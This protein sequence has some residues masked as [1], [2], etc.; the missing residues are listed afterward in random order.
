MGKIEINKGGQRIFLFALIILMIGLIPFLSSIITGGVS[1]GG[2]RPDV[3]LCY[4]EG[5]SSSCDG[6]YPSNCPASGGTDYLSC[7][8]GSEESHSS[9]RGNYA[10]VNASYND[11]SVTNCV[12]ISM[13]QV[14]YEWRASSTGMS[15]C[16]I[17]IDSQGDG[18]YTI[19]SVCP[20]TSGSS[21]CID[22]TNFDSGFGCDD[23]F[24]L[25][26]NR[27]KIRSRQTTPNA[28]SITAYWDQLWY[29]VTYVAAG[30]L[31][32]TL[33]F[34]STSLTNNYLVYDVFII[35]ATIVCN[36]NVG[37][38]CG[39]VN[40][41]LRYN[42]SS[43]E[44][45]VQI[46]TTSGAQPFFANL[47]VQN[48]GKLNATLGQNICTL[49]WN[50]NATQSG[51]WKV[52]VLFQSDS[53]VVSSNNTL[54]AEIAVKPAI[55]S[56]NLSAPIVDSGI[57][58]QENFES[59]CSINCT[60]QDCTDV[61]VFLIY[62]NESLSCN[63]DKLLNTESFGLIANVNSVNLETVTGNTIELA[64]FIVTGDFYGDYV[65]SCNAS[66]SNAG[67]AL[68]ET[69]LPLHINGVPVADFLF[70][71]AN[72]WLHGTEILD[73]SDSIDYDGTITNYLFELDNNYG[74]SSSSTLCNGVSDSCSFNTL[75]QSQCIE[76]STSCYLKL[77][78]TDD[79]SKTNSTIIQI[80][81]DNLA[82]IVTLD[83]PKNDTYIL[84]ESKLINVSVS[85]F[86]SGV[87][88]VLFEGYYDSSWNDLGEDC[89][90]SYEFNWDLSSL[91]DQ[92]I[93]VRARANDSEGNLGDYD[94]H[95]N[96]TYD[97]TFPIIIL[98]SLLENE[99]INYTPYLLNV[100][101]SS[102][103]LSGIANSSWYY[104]SGAQW[105]LIGSDLN[106][107]DG[108]T[109]SWDIGISDGAY[110]FSI[111]VSDKAG[112]ENF[113][114]VENVVIDIV[115]E[116]P[117]CEIVYPNGGVGVNSIVLINASAS[118]S[119]SSDIV[120]NVSFEYSPDNGGT[121]YFIGLNSTEDLDY[122]SFSWDSSLDIDSNNYLV[123]CNVSDSRGGEGNDVSDSVFSVDNSPPVVSLFFP[124]NESFFNSAT[125]LFNFSA[126]DVFTDILECSLIL[127][128]EVNQTNSSVL[129][130]TVTEFV[131]SGLEEG[132][133]LWKVNCSDAG[134]N[135]DF[136]EERIF[137]TD[138]QAPVVNF[139]FPLD[140]AWISNPNLQLNYTPNEGHL[141]SCELWGNFTG[142][143]ELNQ[144]NSE[145]ISGVINSFEVFLE[146]GGY[147]WNVLCND[148]GGN[149]A[150]N[151]TNYS[152]YLDS[153]NPLILYNPSTTSSS[154]ISDKWIFINV[155]ANDLN[156]EDLWF[157]WTNSSG[158][159][160]LSFNNIDGDFYWENKSELDSGEYSFIV[161]INDSAGNLN[162]TLLRSITIDL[163]PPF[164]SLIN[165]TIGG[166]YS[167]VFHR[168][169]LINLSVNWSDDWGL[170]LA[171]LST[172][173]SGVWENKTGYS[174]FQNLSGVLNQSIFNWSNVSIIP[175]ESVY[176]KVYANDSLG[177]LN[178]SSE[179]GFEIWGWSE[180]GKSYLFPAGIKEG[181]ETTMFC[182]VWDNST[183]EGIENYN[184]SFYNETGFIGSNLTDS[185]GVAQ[186][187][188]N[189]STSGSYLITCNLTDESSLHYNDSLINQGYATLGVGYGLFVYDYTN[190]ENKAYEGTSATTITEIDDL[191]TDL[192]SDNNIYQEYEAGQGLYGYTRFEFKI[193]DA[194]NSIT[195]LNITWRGY[196]DVSSGT[197]GYILYIYNESLGDWQQLSSYTTN[198]VEQLAT[199]NFNSDF[200]NLINSTG[201]LKFLA[202]TYS[203][204]PSSGPTRWARIDTDYIKVEVYTDILAPIVTLNF[205]LEF[206]NSS[207]N[208]I[209]FSCYVDDDNFIENVSLYGDWNSWH[210][211][212]TNS[213]GLNL[214]YY[215][216]SKEISEGEYDWNCYSCDRAG[217]C[218]WALSNYSFTVDVTP[219]LV[220]LFYPIN[221]YNFSSFLVPSF[222]FSVIDSNA[223][224]NCSLYGDWNFWHLNQTINAPVNNSIL[225]FSSKIVPGDDY[226]IWNIRCID[227][228]G[229]VGSNSL[230]FSFASF[231]FPDKLNF[232]YFNISQTMNDGTGEITLYWNLSNHSEKYRV[233][234][235]DDLSDDFVYLNDTSD[236]NYTDVSFNGERRRFYRVDSWNPT[237]QNI[238]ETYFGAHVYS[239]NHNGNTRNWLGFP[240]NFSYLISASDSFNE[241]TNTTAFSM[242]NETI[243]GRVTCNLF[244]CPESF[245]CTTTNCD[246]NLNSGRG[247]EANLNSSAPSEVNW[248]GV[249]IVYD[250]INIELVKNETSFGKNWI[251][252]YV[253]TSLVNA[254][255]VLGSIENS[256]AVTTW[257]SN[258]QI[259][260]GLIPSPFP[261]VPYLGTNFNLNLE[262]GYEV[263]V[264]ADTSWEQ[265]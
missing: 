193:N 237:G 62:C 245:A 194:V 172:N 188:F 239:L 32:S 251:S 177:N 153:V 99:I 116:N 144:T 101:S 107:V 229:N 72:D 137:S 161:Y 119:D 238:S 71:L 209:N 138:Y 135:Q 263:S 143:W 117:I 109:Y 67:G 13:V 165:Q 214:V 158:S 149:S 215:N 31:N 33:N 74:F 222:N 63:P 157:E 27:A 100:S 28:P 85:D 9:R 257:D 30:N 247:Y 59:N 34:P 146:D 3:V 211:N 212:Q 21:G 154:L 35:N 199:F 185:L 182:E 94:I 24:G 198:N 136:S 196:G 6:G 148:T 40:G 83:E 25:G 256:D 242:W 134:S 147:L 241:I 29:N 218:E 152:F 23:F 104:F 121:W 93:E 231:L 53:G 82:P 120:K 145:V 38:T 118:D 54:N 261:W 131:V 151:A 246:F 221:N 123:R 226:Y 5:V 105:N 192:T 216:F 264:T 132:D 61:E 47:G 68:S 126:V 142:T 190:A 252:I 180:I 181:Y 69:D 159:F 262:G 90:G 255:D 16:A 203:V 80:G 130:N 60:G 189:V 98:D 51:P 122:Y 176:W 202:R 207:F 103:L 208:Q 14:C 160:N 260:R 36:G 223:L 253:N 77:T 220:D 156:K 162:S 170:S 44:P 78:V 250:K 49:V 244:S 171:W 41:T 55:L 18:W 184:V 150:F 141:D 84:S 163:I 206:Y 42:S 133:Y 195:K 20:G 115:N 183:S 191:Y 111:N 39:I 106:F 2:L 89:V 200:D 128:G 4:I 88:C 81:I 234:S 217:N 236:L 15:S 232:S 17:D 173:E 46:S 57:S 70:P 26:T 112:N 8:D 10:G 175:G 168:G 265:E 87:D 58:E 201:Y 73:A 108:L 19:Y 205:P 52:D 225:N 178:V 228:A 179:K 139:D 97:T 102:D 22:V 164:W 186:M 187:S 48:C 79:Y 227:Y 169:D 174:S 86:G 129:N 240:T 140:N 224:V 249:G 91:T 76:E 210:L 254:Q 96:I 127:N 243:Q 124:N 155:T 125:Q 95:G 11:S 258:S 45:N 92:V 75:I 37:D 114:L 56:A 204:A 65:L 12:E 113:S 110:N 1:S 233:Y 166:S 235:S 248:S 66:S 197:D 259:T 50:V 219:P 7:N 213:S 230:N 43:V 167:D 64:T